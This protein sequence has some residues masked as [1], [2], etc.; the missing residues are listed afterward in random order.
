MRRGTGYAGRI[1][2]FEL[3][4]LDETIRNLV[5]SKASLHGIRIA[6]QKTGFVGLREEG[7]LKALK[8]ATSLEEVL[9]V[10]QEIES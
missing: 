1:G 5:V 3:M 10:T 6:A 8:G 4:A 7:L 9:R 2:L